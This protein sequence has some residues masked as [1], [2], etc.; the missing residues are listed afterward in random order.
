MESKYPNIA[1]LIGVS[2]I[3]SIIY[4]E[5]QAIFEAARRII[6]LALPITLALRANLLIMCLVTKLFNRDRILQPIDEFRLANLP[7]PYNY[8][9][10]KEEIHKIEKEDPISYNY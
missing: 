7:P 10:F 9:H 4:S 8:Q 3:L 5:N 1:T 2:T 6:R